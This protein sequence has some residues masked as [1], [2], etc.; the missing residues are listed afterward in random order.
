M[1]NI[2]FLLLGYYAKISKIC[3]H[4]SSGNC[5]CPCF[6]VTSYIFPCFSVTSFQLHLTWVYYFNVMFYTVPSNNKRKPLANSQNLM[7]DPL[8]H[9]ISKWS[10]TISKSCSKCWKTSNV[11]LTILRQYA[12][13]LYCL[14]VTKGHAY[15]NKPAVKS[16]RFV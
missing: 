5:Q 4:F 13:T 2:F 11:C 6:S 7:W 12:L 15:L 10:D 8:I 14:V 16:C 9:N 1:W 3:L